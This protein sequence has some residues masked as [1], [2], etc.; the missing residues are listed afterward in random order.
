MIFPGCQ[1][2][3]YPSQ[4]YNQ[5]SYATHYK[6]E[7]DALH[8]EVVN[9]LHCP[10]RVWMFSQDTSINHK[11]SVFNPMV[12]PPMSDTVLT[13]P[14]IDTLSFKID[15]ASRLGDPS[16]DVSPPQVSLPFPD[17]KTYMIIQGNNTDFT[18]NNDWSRYALDFNLK[19]YDTICAAAGGFVVGVV[20]QYKHGGPEER[21]RNYGNFVTLFDPE[22]GIFIQYAHLVHRGS[23]VKVGD[24][25]VCGQPISL[26]GN[27]GQS[28]EE[29]LHFSCMVPVN[30]E[31]GLKSIPVVFKEGYKG[32]DLKKNDQVSK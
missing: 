29:H 7:S 27:T 2:L 15:F 8:I 3:F 16:A 24:Q 17:G 19:T 25:V 28:T 13:I 9:P 5:Y 12:L 26:S 31:L 20:D 30:T 14:G 10:L 18:H 4:T 22:S 1:L 11:I 32:E 21:W 23:L 6:I